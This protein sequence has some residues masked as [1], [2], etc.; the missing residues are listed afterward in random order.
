MTDV[1]VRLALYREFVAGGRAPASARLAELWAS[2]WKRSARRRS[3]WPPV[4]R[5]CCS[6]RTARC[7]TRRRYRPCRPRSS[8]TASGDRTSLPARGTRWARLRCSAA[9]RISNRVRLLRGSDGGRGPRRAVDRRAGPDSLCRARTAVVVGPG[10]HVKDDAALPWRRAHRALAAA[11]GTATRRGPEHRAGVGTR[12]RVVWQQ[13][14]GGMAPGNTG[15]GGGASLSDRVD[16]RVL[17]LAAAIICLWKGPSKC[18]TA[19][20]K[21]IGRT[22]RGM[23]A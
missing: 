10:V 7:C 6:R 5:S 9:T 22:R 4:A 3:G 18:S 12:A 11:V 2:R 17:E 15:R 20:R 1:D 23:P 16:G 8:H 19:S 13:D 21:R 14:V